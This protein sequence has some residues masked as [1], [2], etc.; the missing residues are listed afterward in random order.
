MMNEI[1]LDPIFDP[2]ELT[3]DQEDLSENVSCHE[4]GNQIQKRHYRSAALRLCKDCSG[5]VDYFN[6]G[7]LQSGWQACGGGWR[8]LVTSAS[9]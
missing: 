3:H 5:E 8:R 9:N 4:C 6:L 1:D 7:R 2:Q